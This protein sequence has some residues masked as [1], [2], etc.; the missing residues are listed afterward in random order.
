MD[1]KEIVVLVTAPSIEVAENISNSLLESELAACANIIPSI[2][3]IYK[4]KGE[5]HNDEEVL[6]II[7]TRYEL[8]DH[9]FEKTIKEQHPY[10]IPE[11]IALPIVLGSGDYLQ[12][13]SDVTKKK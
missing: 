9:D 5:I 4:W 13:I 6:I 11:I 1:I 2:H 8:F 7:K 3:S 12:W 10:D